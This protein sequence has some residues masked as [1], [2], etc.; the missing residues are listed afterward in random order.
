MVFRSH[1]DDIGT[2]KILLMKSS[3][4]CTAIFG[5]LISSP[6]AAAFPVETETTG[7]ASVVTSRSYAR[8]I[9]AIE[10]SNNAVE[11]RRLGTYSVPVQRLETDGSV[12]FY[13]DGGARTTHQRLRHDKWGRVCQTLGEMTVCRSP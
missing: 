11:N 3:P 7:D 8:P 9:G 2:P 4:F 10:F 6:A 1:S 13:E 5:I 12:I